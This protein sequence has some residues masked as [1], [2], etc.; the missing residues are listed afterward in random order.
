MATTPITSAQFVA[1]YCN[2]LYPAAVTPHLVGA[3]G[4][5]KSYTVERALPAALQAHLS[6]PAPPP[7]V[8]VN[9]GLLSPEDC[10]GYLVPSKDPSG[11]PTSLFT[12]S[13]IAREVRQHA[14]A[15]VGLLFL[16]EYAQAPQDTRKVLA[17]LI[18]GEGR[19]GTHRDIL[20]PGWRVILASNR[21][22]DR[23]GAGAG[24]AFITNRVAR[25]EWALDHDGW[26]R[27]AAATDPATGRARVHP[28]IARF[29]SVRPA[30]IAE[31]VPADPDQPFPSFRSITRAS[32]VITAASPD[33][34]T[35]ALLPGLQTVVAGL[36]GEPYAVELFAFLQVA[37]ELPTP[38]EVL[39]DPDGC[40][41]PP[42][43]RLDAQYAA[44]RMALHFAAPETLEPVARFVQRLRA[45]FQTA[46]MHDLIERLAGR[47]ASPESRRAVLSAPTL[48]RWAAEN[49]Q[50]IS[51]TMTAR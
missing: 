31:T 15:P 4:A 19:I 50:L 13:P 43:E 25:L 17:P 22:S 10:H 12:E 34:W 5:G 48:A 33:G 27:F 9:A 23:S 32:D 14:P 30:L 18:N 40:R 51:A 24:L 1:L 20:P 49:R 26:Q 44:S 28:L 29:V 16:D 39:A 21:A 36:V 2:A 35:P 7:V 38:A 8:T 6:L 45:E 11:R 42:P 41:C 47:S 46:A 3:P 37:Q